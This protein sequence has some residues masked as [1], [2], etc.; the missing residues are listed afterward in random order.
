LLELLTTKNTTTNVG[1]DVEIKEH[2]YTDGGN[3]NHY[4]H[5]ENSMEASQKTKYRTAM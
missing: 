3:V 2:L 4:N 5:M 1:K